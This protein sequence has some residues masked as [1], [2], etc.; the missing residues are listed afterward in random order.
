VGC[1]RLKSL[2]RS[3]ELSLFIQYYLILEKL[4]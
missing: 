1:T 3:S 4:L 2:M